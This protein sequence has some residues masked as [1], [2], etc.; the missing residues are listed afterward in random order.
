M[1]TPFIDA[2]IYA[3]LRDHL[4]GMTGAPEIVLPDEV[5]TPDINNPFIYVTDVR[6]EPP[7]RFLGS[8]DPD[9]HRGFWMVDLMTPIAW[10]YPQQL[11]LF[12]KVQSRF[13]KGLALSGDVTVRVTDTPN[14]EGSAY[15][16]GAFSRLPVK[17]RWRCSG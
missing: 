15:R 3:L 10:T 6:L 16:D 17:V 11:G 2:K 14:I 5:F 8:D 13:N 1:T 7:R 9:E 4:I 12:G